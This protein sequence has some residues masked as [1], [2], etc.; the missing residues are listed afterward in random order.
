LA[1]SRKRFIKFSFLEINEPEPP[2]D[3]SSSWRQLL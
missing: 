2:I 1:E 3:F